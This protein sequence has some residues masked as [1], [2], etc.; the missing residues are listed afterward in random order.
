MAYRG[1]ASI[2]EKFTD[3]AISVKEKAK[4]ALEE[5]GDKIK[6]TRQEWDSG[7]QR[8]RYDDDDDDGPIYRGNRNY[9]GVGASVGEALGDLATSVKRTTDQLVQE[10]K[11][12]ETVRAIGS[13]M[14]ELGE[15]AGWKGANNPSARAS[16]GR[17]DG[18]VD[19]GKGRNTSGMPEGCYC[20][21]RGFA[22]PLHRGREKWREGHVFQQHVQFN[23]GGNDADGTPLEESTARAAAAVATS[24]SSVGGRGQGM[25]TQGDTEAVQ[26]AMAMAAAERAEHI[27]TLVAMGFTKDMAERAL[28][29]YHSLAA[30]T[31]ALLDG[32][33]FGQGGASA[34]APPPTAASPGAP[35]RVQSGEFVSG[36]GAPPSA[37][38]PP[39]PPGAPRLAPPP[40]S[41]ATA[42]PGPTVGDLLDL[43]DL[44]SPAPAP[45]APMPTDAAVVA[46]ALLAAP[47]AA[48]VVAAPA[49]QAAPTAASLPGAA[50]M[51]A[52]AAV[53]ASPCAATP[54][55]APP[56]QHPTFPPMQQLS[57]MPP[58]GPGMAPPQQMGGFPPFAGG[59]QPPPAMRPPMQQ[60]GSGYPPAQQY[61]PTPGASRPACPPA[62]SSSF[63]PAAMPQ[64]TMPAPRPACAAAATA[65]AASSASS[66]CGC[67][68]GATSG[69]TSGPA[70]SA[71]RQLP[72][73]WESGVDPASGVTYY[74]NSSRGVTQWEFPTEP[75]PPAA[76][77]SAAV[78]PSVQG[79]LSDASLANLVQSSD[80][81]SFDL[82]VNPAA[83]GGAAPPTAAKPD[84]LLG[85]NLP[86]AQLA[87]MSAPAK[88]PASLSVAT[89]A[90][91]ASTVATASTAAAAA[92]ETASPAT[93]ATPATSATSA[94]SAAPVTPA[95]ASRQLPAGW[96]S[97]V[98]PAS[99]VTYYCNP[100]RGVTQWE[101]PLA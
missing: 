11:R 32:E 76:A 33:D 54:P 67:T 79:G 15:G 25:D 92:A 62:G 4:E 93:P 72:A 24:S 77:T 90:S 43:G 19:D 37:P 1:D 41:T 75:P 10:A 58:T 55:T 46:Q 73:G 18:W 83:G 40:G 7:G 45:A 63:P 48:P 5:V 3:L 44:S 51:M 20:D 59:Q 96:E 39:P 97:G 82:R 89:P 17:G 23:G 94:T 52:P 91:T 34:S 57:G 9:E 100:A 101:F 42:P 14:D 29:K 8:R 50:A 13:K 78:P 74:C 99:G 87:A 80:I 88:Q 47:P 38:P 95:S 35:P 81:V 64:P 65:A 56:P 6:E 86:L 71:S 31:N 16:R 28:K 49:P 12:S 68:S 85:G 98:D 69:A 30:A 84:S 60:P 2:G 22:C 61:V 66:S 27:E 53:V 70:A 26:R 36:L 21:M